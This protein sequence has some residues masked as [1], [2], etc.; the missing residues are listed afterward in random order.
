MENKDIESTYNRPDGDRMIDAS[1][2]LIDLPS[3][4][5]QIKGEKQW[6]KSDRNSITVFK[7]DKMRIVLTALRKNAQMQTQH[8]ENIL[9]LHLIDGAISFETQ[10]KKLEIESGQIVALHDKIPYTVTALKKTLLLLTIVE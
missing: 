3:F 8:P 4:K 1:V 6:K 7:S 10:L 9:S 5:K 2:L